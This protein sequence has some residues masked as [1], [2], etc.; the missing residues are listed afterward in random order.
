MI[1]RR[2]EVTCHPMKTSQ[3]IFESHVWDCLQTFSIIS[4]QSEILKDDRKY[5]A[6]IIRANDTYL[7][8]RLFSAYSE[9]QVIFVAFFLSHVYFKALVSMSTKGLSSATLGSNAIY[10]IS[11]LDALHKDSYH[12][13]LR[14]RS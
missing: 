12:I 5:F 10:V 3:P 7:H 11:C 2:A 1:I 6:S 4:T 8:C 9:A 14:L 13:Q